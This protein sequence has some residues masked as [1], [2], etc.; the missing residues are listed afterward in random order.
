M[1]WRYDWSGGLPPPGTATAGGIHT[2]IKKQSH[3][4]TEVKMGCPV[5]LI[6]KTFS[7]SLPLHKPREILSGLGK[8]QHTPLT[9][10]EQWAASL[11]YRLLRLIQL[12]PLKVETSFK[13]CCV[14]L[15][16]DTYAMYF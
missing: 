12:E 8:A 14:G 10:Q 9:P 11:S 1:V 7:H 6:H 5:R 2:D 4:R 16:N 13:L 3:F 15:V